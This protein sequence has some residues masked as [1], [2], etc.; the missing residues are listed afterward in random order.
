MSSKI[1]AQ[2]PA[3]GVT[4]VKDWGTSRLY[5]A[6]CDC[7]DDNCTQT[8][9]IEAEDSGVTV[10]IY[11]Q[12]R[13][14]FWSKNRWQNLWQLLTRGH[15]EYETS[16]IMNQQVALNYLKTLES[17]MQDVEQLKSKR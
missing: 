11:T 13:S 1:R 9:D 17:A 5:K 12:V 15:T 14:N 7:T 10:T 3:Q 16:L 4:L 2:K 8:I 6:V